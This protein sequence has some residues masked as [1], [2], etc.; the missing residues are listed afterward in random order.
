[1]VV[2]GSLPWLCEIEGLELLSEPSFPWYHDID[3]TMI[4]HR[5]IRLL[6]SETRLWGH[7][8]ECH[9][10]SLTVRFFS[11]VPRQVPSAA[12]MVPVALYSTCTSHLIASDDCTPLQ[13]IHGIQGMQGIQAADQISM[14]TPLPRLR[15][16]WAGH[17]NFVIYQWRPGQQWNS[18]TVAPPQ[19]LERDG[20]SKIELLM[21]PMRP[22]QCNPHHRLCTI[23]PA[24]NDDV[25]DVCISV[26]CRTLQSVLRVLS[27]LA[28]S[29]TF[30]HFSSSWTSP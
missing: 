8:T 22:F 1:M 4:V 19:T 11:V 26:L 21:M 12:L 17:G 7:V 14:T 2:L 3:I 28:E 20:K 9:C 23:P 25:N 13:G 29:A 18:R 6:D 16:I 30:T 27:E 24:G 5:C 10:K 15:R